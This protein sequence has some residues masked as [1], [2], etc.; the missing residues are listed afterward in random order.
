M[1]R[2]L[3]N[4]IWADLA[5]LLLRRIEGA[6][7]FTVFGDGPMGLARLPD[8][9]GGDP[10]QQNAVAARASTGRGFLEILRAKA[11]FFVLPERLI[12]DV[13]GASVPVVFSDVFL[14][15][16]ASTRYVGNT[17]L[18]VQLNSGTPSFIASW[19]AEIGRVS[20]VADFAPLGTIYH[21]LCHAWMID[22]VAD[23][24]YWQDLDTRSVEHYRNAV[25]AGG[26]AV[27]PRRAYREAA[28]GYVEARVLGWYELLQAFSNAR[29]LQG[30]IPD[31]ALA[32]L[33]TGAR[34]KYDS[35]ADQQVFGSVDESRIVE[36]GLP[37]PL[38]QGLDAYVLSSLPLTRRFEQTPLRTVDE[39]VFGGAAMAGIT[40]TDTGAGPAWPSQPVLDEIATR[41]RLAEAYRQLTADGW[42]VRRRN[43]WL[44]NAEIDDESSP[45]TLYI[46]DDTEP[47]ATLVDWLE[48]AARLA[49]QNDD[50]YRRATIR[51]HALPLFRGSGPPAGPTALELMAELYEW[52]AWFWLKRNAYSDPAPF[53]ND[54]VLVLTESNPDLVGD[55]GGRFSIFRRDRLFFWPDTT[56]F[57]REF[58]DASNQVRHATASIQASIL[59]GLLGLGAGQFREITGGGPA[60]FRLNLACNRIASDLTTGSTALADVAYLLRAIL[61]DPAQTGEYDGPVLGD[62]DP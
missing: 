40:P 3:P 43:I 58:R 30:T 1:S 14:G 21:E 24:P 47:V 29:L 35:I 9:L 17:T 42:Q 53:T 28:G 22:V 55:S 54:M 11:H 4:P 7:E 15:G 23:D 13:R 62:P 60:D 10:A 51:D 56:G 2:T 18:G 5:N 6:H 41:P 25:T 39:S 36:P 46:D 38:R 37:E 32:D 44:A 50:D 19:G 49:Y 12:D 45:K 59:Y 31:T 34:V 57:R 33:L 27:D 20:T 48:D 52:S 8:A 26:L 61:G 16:S